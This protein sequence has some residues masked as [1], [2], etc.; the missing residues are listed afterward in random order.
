MRVVLLFCFL[1]FLSSETFAQGEIEKG[2]SEINFSA[3]YLT[4]TGDNDF[5]V[6]LINFSYGYYVTDNFQLGIGPSLS[7][8]SSGSNTET[9]LS[10]LLFLNYNFSTKTKTIPYFT[11]YWYQFDFDIP[12][13]ASF[14]DLAFVNVGFGV[15]NFF[16]R[17]VA[18]DTKVTYGFSLAE[19]ADGGIIQVLS[20]FS[21]IF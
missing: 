15:K 11:A 20:G 10:G 21:V 18:L 19:N 7:I 6:G 4:T 12:K 9:T 17:Y 13:E 3:T 2:D 16:N 14:T 8:S 1:V 5:S